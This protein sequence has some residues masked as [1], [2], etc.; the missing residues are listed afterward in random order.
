[1]TVKEISDHKKNFYKTQFK[2]LE[3]AYNIFK[4]K[5]F[6]ACRGNF[7]DVDK[8]LCITRIFKNSLFITFE[9]L[10][11]NDK[12]EEIINGTIA[13][14]DPPDTGHIQIYDSKF[15]DG[16]SVPYNDPQFSLI[17][18]KKIQSN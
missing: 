17:L 15:I 8:E 16:I 11:D 14:F 7:L 1:M 10:L 4:I 9:Q 18:N 12:V 3:V 6:N 5:V 13:I 2:T